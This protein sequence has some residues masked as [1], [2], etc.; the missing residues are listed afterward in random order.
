MKKA[1]HQ[2]SGSKLKAV[3]TLLFAFAVSFVLIYRYVFVLNPQNSDYLIHFYA[4]IVSGGYSLVFFLIPPF[5]QIT[6]S[7]LGDVFLISLFIVFTVP[8]CALFIRKL[9][10]FMQIEYDFYDLF[11]ISC[12]LLFLCKLCIPEISPDYYKHNAFVTQPWHNSTYIAMRLFGILTVML[13]YQIQKDYRKK[14][15]LKQCAVFT[16]LLFLTNFSKPNFIIVF[17]PVMLAMLVYDFICSRGKTFRNAFIFGM[18]VLLACPILF[19]EKTRIFDTDIAAGGVVF[20]FEGIVNFFLTD[21]KG[22]L[23]LLLNYAFPI[24]VTALVIR[25]RSRLDSFSKRI[26]IQAWAMNTLSVLISFFIRET[27]DRATNGNFGWGNPFFAFQLF[28]V[29]LV[30]LYGMYRNKDVSEKEFATARNIYCLHIVFGL[31]Y[32]FLLFMGYKSWRI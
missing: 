31:C 12:S 13:Y 10:K 8:A 11:P 22:L 15:D 20:S 21:K 7:Y 14:I 30:M 5:Y 29:C 1:I 3:I 28:A 27:G 9:L 18:C 2:L 17:A 25:N 4:A 26:M 23:Y 24:V 32:Y 16:L 19:Y 6:G